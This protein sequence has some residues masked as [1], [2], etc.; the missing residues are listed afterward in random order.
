MNIISNVR[1]T[2]SKSDSEVNNISNL[3]N[4]TSTTSEETNAATAA[5]EKSELTRMNSKKRKRVVNLLVRSVGNPIQQGY[6]SSGIG[7]AS[8]IHALVVIFLEFFAWGLLTDQVI[9]VSLICSNLYFDHSF[10]L[11]FW[12]R[13][14]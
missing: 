7:K 5:T 3:T 13:L 4:N 2:N 9:T 11:I 6:V 14:T 12:L 10:K 1:S 8:F